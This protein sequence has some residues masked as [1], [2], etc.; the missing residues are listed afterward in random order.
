MA[1]IRLSTSVFAIDARQY[2]S[3][4]KKF[5]AEKMKELGRSGI[6]VPISGG[7]DSSVVASLCVMAVGNRNV[8]GL[9]LPEKQGNPDADKYAKLLARHLKI[10]T[11]TID[12]SR[13]L[14][15]HGAYDFILS[16][17]PGRKIKGRLVQWF[18]GS[19]NYLLDFYKG[20]KKAIVRKGVA[21]F[22]I[23]QRVRLVSVY[24]FAEER[25]LLVCGSAHKS[26][27]LVGLYVKFGVDDAADVMPLK[28][29]YR[30]QILALAEYCAIP[31]EIVSRTP[32]PDV[33]PGVT[34]KY[35]DIIGVEAGTVDLVL[36]G[37]ENKM[38]ARAIARDAGITEKKVKEIEDLVGLTEHTRNPSMAP[39]FGKRSSRK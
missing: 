24:K 32:N 10:K 11:H 7:L 22:F 21:S 14:A 30:T 8:T 35:Q 34:D 12:I 27:D 37:I 4:I 26:E 28:N 29:L 16:R 15:G 5:I 2:A 20:T 13:P 19:E 17:F 1:A 39:V 18:K 9:L 33:I 25:N 36:F 38:N 31:K 3:I 23:K 6:V